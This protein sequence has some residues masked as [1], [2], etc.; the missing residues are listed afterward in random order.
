MTTTRTAMGLVMIFALVTNA[1]ADA[2][3]IAKALDERVN[4]AVKQCKPQDLVN[5]YEKDAV[6]IYPGEGEIGR[7]KVEI[8]RLVKTFFA[9]FCPDEKKKV[10]EK[11]VSF[12]AIQVGPKYIMIIR[13][14]DITD[15]DG[16]PARLRTTELIHNSAGNWWYVV[17]HASI[18]V[19][20]AP[21]AATTTK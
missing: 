3:A 6:A 10:T 7:N 1:R 20:P 9:A 14:V 15:R 11:D 4:N 19:P 18:G 13:I 8:E 2:L 17:D 21:P 16:N 12:D 5:L